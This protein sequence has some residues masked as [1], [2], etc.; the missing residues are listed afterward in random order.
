MPRYYRKRRPLRPARRPAGRRYRYRKGYRRAVPKRLKR[1]VKRAIHNNIENKIVVKNFANQ[2]VTTADTTFQV[3]SINL[4]PD[5]PKG[6]EQGERLG[7]KIKPV[8]NSIRGF[9]NMKPHNSLTNPYA[10]VKVRLM[11]V[12]YKLQNR[13]ANTLQLSD[14]SRI[15]EAGNST[16]GFQGNMLDMILPINK[17][18]WIIYENRVIN[19]GIG[20][21]SS[22]FSGSGFTYDASR[23][24]VPFSFNCVKHCKSFLTFDDTSS[25]RPTNRNLYMLIQPVSAEGS[26]GGGIYTPIEMHYSHR[27]EFEDA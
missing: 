13:N 1:Y 18:D 9:I 26:A 27:F 6:T 15:F 23:F 8:V 12:S 22:A 10:P 16:V 5:V 17:A 24:S 19:V 14:F 25:S 3:A 7:I 2:S 21:E 20:S 4:L 11:I